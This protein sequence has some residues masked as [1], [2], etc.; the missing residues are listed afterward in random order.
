MRVLGYAIFLSCFIPLISGEGVHGGRTVM[1]AKVIFVLGFLLAV[2]LFLVSGETWWAVFSGF[3]K[4]G[5]LPEGEVDW[6]TLAAFAAVAG[7]GGL[8]NTLFSN[9]A[10][11]KGWGMGGACRGDSELDWREEDCTV[12]GGKGIRRNAGEPEALEGVAG[13]HPAGS[14]LDLG[15]GIFDRHGAAVDAVAGVPAG[16]GSG[17]A[18]GGCDDGARYCGSARRSVLVSDIAVRFCGPGHRL[19]SDP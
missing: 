2:D 11:D 8:S 9:Y 19:H 13:I 16:R 6:A 15:R 12:A 14:D 4:V 10:R 1:T 3:F 5:M 17:G 7:V 18:C